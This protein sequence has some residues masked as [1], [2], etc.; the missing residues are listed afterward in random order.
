MK[1]SI[2]ETIALPEGCKATYAHGLLTIHGGK[3]TVSRKVVDPKVTLKVE[4][5]TIVL[6]YKDGSKREK[7]RLF[8]QKAHIKNLIKG[9]MEGHEYKLKICASHFPMNVSVTGNELQVKNFFGEKVP[10]KVKFDPSVKVQVAG[11][12]ITCN[13]ANKEV[14]AQ[15]AA[16]IEQLTRRS[17]FDK[18]VFQDG[19]YITDKD[20]KSP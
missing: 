2:E 11:E 6:A 13:G 19:I 9:S 17:S 18:R 12:I 5:D 15:T 3:A 10:R 14:V 20:G 16:A 1:N 4:H 8:T 7:T